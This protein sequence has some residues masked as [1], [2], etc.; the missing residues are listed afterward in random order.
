[1]TIYYSDS[2]V[3]FV[4]DGL[5]VEQ[6]LIETGMDCCYFKPSAMMEDIMTPSPYASSMFTL[7]DG[8]IAYGGH[9]HV[10][11]QG[12]ISI[13]DIG[14]TAAIFFRDPKAYSGQSINMA[15]EAL[16]GSEFAAVISKVRGKPF[17]FKKQSNFFLKLI[18]PKLF[19]HLDSLDAAFYEKVI[20]DFHKIHPTPL[21]VEQFLIK[22][23]FENYEIP[24]N[25][26][27]CSIM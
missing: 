11:P 25:K 21:T 19:K 4:E 3:W 27:S 2:G 16:T 10:I 24:S 1:M 9:E 17:V 7:R 15:S 5:K 26:S 18:L 14:I 6:Q 20:S 13:E 22:N 12:F 8:I 23:H